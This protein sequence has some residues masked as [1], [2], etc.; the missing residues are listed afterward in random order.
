MKE[1]CEDEQEPKQAV[2]VQRLPLVGYLQMSP[3]PITLFLH[4]YQRQDGD[5]RNHFSVKHEVDRSPQKNHCL[6][7]SVAY[8]STLKR[9]HH[10]TLGCRLTFTLEQLLHLPA[11]RQGQGE[12]LNL[13]F[14]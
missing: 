3:Q 6:T 10:T 8:P 9:Y 11:T 13:F 4:A 12:R 2:Q 7:D 14:I 5:H 1:L